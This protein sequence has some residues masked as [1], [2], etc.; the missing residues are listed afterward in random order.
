MCALASRC[1]IVL[2]AIQLGCTA[3]TV[4]WGLQANAEA[5]LRPRHGWPV[6]TRLRLLA[7]TL[8]VAARCSFNLK[9]A[10][11]IATRWGAAGEWR[12]KHQASAFDD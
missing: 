1:T 2:I 6:F 3:A 10:I 4:I 11:C 12:K 8:T 9:S 5:H 7:A